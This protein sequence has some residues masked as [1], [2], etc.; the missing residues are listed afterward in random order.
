MMPKEITGVLKVLQDQGPSVSFDKIKIVVENELKAP[1]DSI[2]DNF[3]ESPI[4]AASLAQVHEAY[5]K[6]SN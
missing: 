1:L 4:A 3:A 6:G 5:L 2:F